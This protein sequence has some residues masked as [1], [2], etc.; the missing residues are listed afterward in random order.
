MKLTR[1]DMDR[2]SFPNWWLITATIVAALIYIVGSLYNSFGISQSTGQ[3]LN[4]VLFGSP[5]G[6]I[7]LCWALAACSIMVLPE[8]EIG[9]VLSGIFLCGVVVFFYI[10]W[11]QTAAIQQHVGPEN[12]HTP[13]WIQG[14]LIGGGWLDILGLAFAVGL[15]G[16]YVWAIWKSLRYYRYHPN[17]LRTSK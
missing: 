5:R 13:T 7:V 15:I 6:A 16:V 4:S 10:W 17:L 3:S 12:Y 1:S 11:D 9:K 2:G 8:I 14:Y